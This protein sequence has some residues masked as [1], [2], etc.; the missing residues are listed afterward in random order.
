ML[1]E[2]GINTY[3]AEFICRNIKKNI[4]FFLIFHDYNWMPR[5][6]MEPR[7]RHSQK[8]PSCHKLVQFHSADSVGLVGFRRAAWLKTS[9]M[10]LS[11]LSV[12]TAITGQTPKWQNN[13]CNANTIRYICTYIEF[14]F[15]R[16]YIK[17]S[18]DWDPGDTVIFGV[19]AV[20]S[21]IKSFYCKPSILRRSKILVEASI[22]D[23]T[24]LMNEIQNMRI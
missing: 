6:P 24:L 14:L 5:R 3:R 4:F 19:F 13:M 18:N 7:H 1:R 2:I 11:V 20:L 8:W 17:F 9:K 15:K 23:N 21:A 10:C 22:Y 16:I 12:D